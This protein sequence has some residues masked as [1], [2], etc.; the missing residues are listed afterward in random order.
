MRPA[1]ESRAEPPNAT[2][3]ATPMRAQA[4][5]EIAA[6][7]IIGVWMATRPS[8]ST[9]RAFSALAKRRTFARSFR[10]GRPGRR[11]GAKTAVA[12]DTPRPSGVLTDEGQGTLRRGGPAPSKRRFLG[13]LR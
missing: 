6:A 13:R 7:A 8:F 2:E 5:M 12:G 10:F 1:R 3:C 4:S 9:P 11:P